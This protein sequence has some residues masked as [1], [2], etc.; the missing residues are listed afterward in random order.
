MTLQLARAVGR[1]HQQLAGQ[2][3]GRLFGKTEPELARLVDGA[4]AWRRGYWLCPEGPA[5]RSPGAA[6][7]ETFMGSG[8]SGEM[9]VAALEDPDRFVTAAGDGLLAIWSLREGREIE[10]LEA[11]SAPISLLRASP[12]GRYLLSVSE[13]GRIRTLASTQD[14]LGTGCRLDGTA[15]KGR[16]RDV[17]GFAG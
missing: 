9:L 4:R 3:V 15:R 10:V 16:K 8:R 5:L 1:D 6:F 13:D 11:H 7:E 12:S 14:R 2:I 17:A